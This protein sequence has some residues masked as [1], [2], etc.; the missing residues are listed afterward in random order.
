MAASGFAYPDQDIDPR[1]K[2]FNWILQYC[3]A[4]WAD[5][6]N[7]MPSAILFN[8]SQN[9]YW[10]IMQY[11][12]GKQS[13]SKYKKIQPGDEPIDNT[14]L[15]NDS[16]VIAIAR[17]FA[18]IAIAKIKQVEYNLEANAVDPLAKSEEDLYFNQMKI[19]IMMRQMLQQ[20][21]STLANSPIVKQQGNEPDDMEQLQMQM[22]F[23]YKHAMALNAE[24]GIQLAFG[25]NNFE[26]Q[27]GELDENLYC[28]GIGG[29]K[30]WIDDKGM[31]KFRA[32]CGENLITSYCLKSDFSDAVHTGEI[33]SVPVTDLV[34]YFNPKQV[35][36]ICKYVAGKFGNPASFDTRQNRWW[37]KFT[38]MVVD[39][40]F[41]SWN[42][43]V[44]KYSV[45]DQGNE[46]GGKTDYANLRFVNQQA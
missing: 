24:E 6:S 36:Q 2:D 26:Q 42:T 25:Q 41:F 10:E 19:K 38:V 43:T 14:E 7:Y 35:E 18:D 20:Q 4:A 16:T 3:K 12:M 17:K 11:R 45:D 34:P 15:N 28:F 46:R 44:Y 39:L 27:R 40:Q 32:V 22:D 1:K 37:D 33:I 5:A 13:I 9:R 29:F 31:P 30:V 21:Q 23:N 8:R